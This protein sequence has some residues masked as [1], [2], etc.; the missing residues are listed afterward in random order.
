MYLQ[1]VEGMH[2]LWLL[3][4]NLWS[5]QFIQKQL[6]SHED[7]VMICHLLFIKCKFLNF[8]THTCTRRREVNKNVITFVRLYLFMP[9]R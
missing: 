9:A 2:W 5:V 8:I 4:F 1:K 7:S 3:F 6:I